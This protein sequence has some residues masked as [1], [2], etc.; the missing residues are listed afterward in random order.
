MGEIPVSAAIIIVIIVI[1]VCR[2][3]MLGTVVKS[4]LKPIQAVDREA[5][6]I[7]RD[8]S[9]TVVV[10]ECTHAANNIITAVTP[11]IEHRPQMVAHKVRIQIHLG[12]LDCCNFLIASVQQFHVLFDV[13]HR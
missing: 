11:L 5:F 3:G 9:P 13:S 1:K 7:I 2:D 4:Q 8:P 6:L 10:P 12:D